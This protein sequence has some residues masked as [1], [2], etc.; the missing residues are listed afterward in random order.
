MQVR[1]ICKDQLKL[2]KVEHMKIHPCNLQK[3]HMCNLQREI[4]WIK[5]DKDA[6]LIV[7]VKDFQFTL[8][9]I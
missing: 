5:I 1:S 4:E 9:N 3:R 7:V 8:Q 2:Q 6:V